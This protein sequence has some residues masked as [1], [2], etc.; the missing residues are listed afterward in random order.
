LKKLLLN[1]IYSVHLIK[2]TISKFKLINFSLHYRGPLPILCSINLLIRPDHRY[3]LINFHC[4]IYLLFHNSPNWLHYL[5]YLRYFTLNLLLRL[6][7]F[8]FAIYCFRSL[9]LPLINFGFCFYCY[10]LDLN[11]H[12][13]LPIFYNSPLGYGF[14]RCLTF[15]SKLILTMIDREYLSLCVMS[16]LTLNSLLK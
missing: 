13:L 6:H 1:S 5:N 12:I 11:H 14:N 3:C 7:F 4:A 10:H 16:N 9:L 15:C 8:C 2:N